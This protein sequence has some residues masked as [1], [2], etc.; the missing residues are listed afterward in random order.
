M[1]PVYKKLVTRASGTKFDFD[2][3]LDND[4]DDLKNLN[5]D[6]LKEHLF[7]KPKPGEKPTWEQKIVKSKLEAHL[8]GLFKLNVSGPLESI[9]SFLQTCN[10]C[11]YSAKV[12]DQTT[13]DL[14]AAT[15]DTL[16]KIYRE[17]LAPSMCMKKRVNAKGGNTIGLGDILPSGDHWTA[18]GL[19]PL[20][21]QPLLKEA[22]KLFAECLYYLSEY[23]QRH[24]AGVPEQLLHQLLSLCVSVFFLT[25][26]DKGV[27]E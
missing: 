24:A 7:S 26:Y 15:V 3:K 14:L 4:N 20:M 18:P 21:L 25:D 22:K 13:D 17:V 5:E 8:T 12:A 6:D 2:F 1:F 27:L 11:F 9:S 10:V 19:T 16:K 23:V